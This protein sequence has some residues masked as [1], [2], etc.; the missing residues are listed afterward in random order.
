M[1]SYFIRNAFNTSK[2]SIAPCH[3]IF[4]QN[5]ENTPPVFTQS[6]ENHFQLYNCCIVTCVL[7]WCISFEV[8]IYPL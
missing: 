4:Q 5:I 3:L 2:D 7:C 1:R 6:E 8:N